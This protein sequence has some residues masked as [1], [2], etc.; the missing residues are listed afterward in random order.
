MRRITFYTRKMKNGKPEAELV[1][2]YT[3]GTYNYY[4]ISETCWCAVHVFSGLAIPTS[5]GPTRRNAAEKAHAYTEVINRNITIVNDQS[6]I[7][8]NMI[9]EAKQNEQL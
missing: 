2:G 9:Q 8:Q 3:D 1:L 5:Y 7:F 6:V 4:K